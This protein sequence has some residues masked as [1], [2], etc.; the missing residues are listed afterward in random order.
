MVTRNRKSE[1]C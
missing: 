1:Y